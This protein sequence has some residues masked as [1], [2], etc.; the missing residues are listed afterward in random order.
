VT[1]TNTGT[2]TATVLAVSASGGFN[3]NNTCASLA[4][5]ASCT[6]TIRFTPTATGTRTGAVSIT[7]NANNSPTTVALSGTGIDTNTNLARARTTTASSQVNGSFT[8]AMATD[9][10]PNTYWESANNA[11]PQWLQVDLG[12]QYSIGRLTLRL[13]PS[14]AWGTRSQ[15]L[16]VLTS[17]DPN[18]FGTAV[19]SASYTF[20][21]P[22]NVVTIAVPTTTARYVRLNFTGNTGW[23]AGQASEFEVYPGGGTNTGTGSASVSGVSV[24]GDFAQTNSVQR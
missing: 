14:S 5:G 3:Q 9:G 24:A 19:G 18:S 8:P 21:S 13:P 6:V 15:T 22:T 20:T 7:S 1:V 16:A 11:F 23:P 4:V 2:A 10:D 17:S 12:V